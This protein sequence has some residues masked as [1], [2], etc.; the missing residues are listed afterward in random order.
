[1]PEKFLSYEDLL[2]E[3]KKLKHKLTISEE[4]N[5]SHLLNLSIN[6]LPIIIAYIDNNFKYK[7]ANDHFKVLH[8]IN[9][10]EIIGKEIQDV[11]GLKVWEID[12]EYYQKAMLGE[13]V[14][15][16][17]NFINNVGID[18]WYQITLIP[19]MVNNNVMG[20]FCLVVDLTDQQLMESELIE[21]EKRIIS[22]LRYEENIA[23]FSSSLLLDVPNAIN[24]GLKHILNATDCSRVY[25]FENFI[26][27]DNK[28]SLKQ[29]HEACAPGVTPEID[30]PILQHVIY[31]EHGY[32]RW[33]DLLSKDKLINDI[34]AEM[35]EQERGALEDQGIKS[36]LVLPVFVKQK[37][38]GFIGFDHT[39]REEK[40][41]DDD[42]N[43]LRSLSETLSLYLDNKQN[44][45]IILEK[46]KELLDAKVILE[47][48]YSELEVAVNK[49][50][51][52]IK[53]K[54]K[55][56]SVLAHDLKNPIGGLKSFLDLTI[57]QFDDL[58][59]KEFKEI[60]HE[61][62]ATSKRA[63]QLL[64][65]LLTWSRSQ[66]GEINVYP[67]S[68]QVL[69]IYNDLKNT[70]EKALNNKNQTLISKIEDNLNVYA[71]KNMIFTVLRNLISNS[72][73]FSP[74]GGKIE[75][76]AQSLDHE[77]I[78]ILIADNGIGISEENL[79]S[80][81][82]DIG[83]STFGTDGEVGTGIGLSFCKD[84][85]EK[86]GGKIWVES[87]IGKGSKFCFTV[88]IAN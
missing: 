34:V 74:K 8:G 19:N 22:R 37:W 78:E 81:F 80:I 43:L 60:L 44:K 73:K 58:S 40:W 56:F 47:S 20:L 16:M 45:E 46:N 32:S 24:N 1:M 76:I 82:N 66:T 28:L 9:N 55:F 62:S 11:I 63:Y 23:K 69:A 33:K 50:D 35:P 12:G 65:N 87:E 17:H 21:N 31:D 85:V 38:F 36:I 14:V 79:K 86:N 41:N 7:I 18:H 68:I 61:M 10:E 75:F 13:Q 5:S 71:D 26:D 52:A 4:I 72:I 83:K 49:A 48:K 25:I 57:S 42:I 67:E 88:P 64:E 59:E 15:F 30:N 39:Q 3:N 53:T 2:E 29:I 77:K 51:E 6:S 70:F 84:F 54:D 27:N